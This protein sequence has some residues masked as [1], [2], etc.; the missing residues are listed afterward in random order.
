MA[1]DPRIALETTPQA[2]FGPNWD[3]INQTATTNQNIQTAQA[4]LPGV[5]AESQIQQRMN[6][7]QQWL[8]Q[9][10]HRFMREDGT[11]DTP[12]AASAVANAGFP[13]MGNGLL[14]H[15][16]NTD[17][18]QTKSASERLD[19]A[20]KGQTGMAAII[21]NMPDGPEKNAALAKQV[22]FV[23]GSA[24]YAPNSAVKMGTHVAQSLYAYDK[25]GN[26]I[27][28][29]NGNPQ[30]DSAKVNAV[31]T[32][33]IPADVQEDIRTN[34]L[35][36]HNGPDAM[37][38]GS[39]LSQST[40]AL[41][42]K[43]GFAKQGDPVQ[44]DWYWQTQRPD[45]QAALKNNAPSQTY[46]EQQKTN[47]LAHGS[48]AATF[49][50]AAD[51]ANEAGGPSTWVPGQMVDAFLRDKG[52][53]PKWGAF[54]SMLAQ[55]KVLDPSLDETKQDMPT[56]M[57]KIQANLGY[58]N[59][60]FNYYG[61]A[62]QTGPS[63]TDLTGTPGAG[64]P[65]TSI[66]TPNTSQPK[67]ST[68]PAT[69]AAAPSGGAPTAAPQAAPVAPPVPTQ[70]PVQGNTPKIPTQTE[71]EDYARR[72]KISVAE[73]KARLSKKLGVQIP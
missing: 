28:D 24:G 47:A 32:A 31:K 12:G 25:D 13:E 26:L 69:P 18:L 48:A 34:Q 21:A 45:F 14:S 65:K 35:Q 22:A 62:S 46:V 19:L 27:T 57:A 49:Q 37:N 54:R 70:S 16:V 23:N 56:L 38:P 67:V 17:M 3:T 10:S 36:N 42:V 52:N 44:S 11:F 8:Q 50:A 71:I 6:A 1:I 61:G 63:P 73:V 15:Y 72:M 68:A 20:N 53:D 59:K 66:G 60:M 5:Q 4:Q 29:V 55:A 41:A 33:T 51:A 9:N 30:V 43:L 7:G 39:S 58:R 2:G 64:T 40:H